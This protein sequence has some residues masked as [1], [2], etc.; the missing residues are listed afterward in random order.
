[1]LNETQNYSYNYSKEDIKSTSKNNGKSSKNGEGKPKFQLNIK[2]EK[3]FKSRSGLKSKHTI[4]NDI[5]KK[6]DELRRSDENLKKLTKKVPICVPKYKPKINSYRPHKLISHKKK[7][8]KENNDSYSEVCYKNLNRYR[9][10]SVYICIYI[11]K[12][13][14]I[15]NFILFLYI[16]I[17]FMLNIM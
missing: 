3:T 12:V 8:I 7:N 5:R 16:Y 2:Q 11:Y 13:L 4:K 17:Y 1:M 10:I 15:I 6:D 14:F 9:R